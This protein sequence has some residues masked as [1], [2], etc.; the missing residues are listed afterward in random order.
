M[1]RKR[2]P[3][4]T[5]DE[6]GEDPGE[7]FRTAIGPVRPLRATPAPPPRPK[8]RAAARMAERDEHDARGEFQR[9]IE[10]EAFHLERGDALAYRREHV[11]ARVLRRL[12]R[13]DYSAQDELDL[14]HSDARRA[15]QLLRSFLANAREAGH[16]CVCIVHGKGLHSEGNFPV[17]KNVVD[18]ILRQR[19][20]VL[21]FHSAPV[22]QGGTGA[23]LV[24]L[25]PRR[26]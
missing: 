21:A 24:L 22:A 2:E 23:V 4:P 9:G 13:G 25:A 16:G 26:G 19:A 15:E 7:M 10:D 14:H 18:R 6:P 8:P 11:P 5:D 20:D 1:I 17:L 12:A 3:T